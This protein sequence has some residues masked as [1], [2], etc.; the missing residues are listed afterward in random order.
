MKKLQKALILASF[1]ALTGCDIQSI[2]NSAKNEQ[3]T[4]QNTEKNEGENHQ[5]DDNKEENTNLLDWP[6][7]Q[8]AGYL[9]QI[10]P[11][12]TT[13]VIPAMVSVLRA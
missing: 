8:I 9:N 7:Q 6:T 10:V 2:F 4:T 12:G 3:E 13:A 11:T 5:N 1:F